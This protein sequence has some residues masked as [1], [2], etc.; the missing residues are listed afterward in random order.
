[1]DYTTCP[2]CSNVN[3]DYL[4]MSDMKTC[5]A[6]GAIFGDVSEPSGVAARLPTTPN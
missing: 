4:P 2:A 5:L 1:M 6:C 3:V